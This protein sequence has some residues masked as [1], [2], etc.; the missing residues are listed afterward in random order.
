MPQSVGLQQRVRRDWVTVLR[1]LQ[2]R[3]WR[4]E[5]QLG[6]HCVSQVEL[7]ED[8][9]WGMGEGVSQTRAEET[10]GDAWISPEALR[11]YQIG[12]CKKRKMFTDLHVSTKLDIR[13]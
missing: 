2:R 5:D 1:C 10:G 12:S 6:G 8:V 11:T 7:E 13:K 9:S 3:G 4:Q